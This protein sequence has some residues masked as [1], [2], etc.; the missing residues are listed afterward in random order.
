MRL[1][2]PGQEN[3]PTPGHQLRI[4]ASAPGESR[5][6]RRRRRG[7]APRSQPNRPER[8]RS[9]RTR[10]QAPRRT[11]DPRPPLGTSRTDRRRSNRNRRRGSQGCPSGPQR[12][13]N[14]VRHPRHQ[15]PDLRRAVRTRNS[16]QTA[17]SSTRRPTRRRR[18]TAPPRRTPKRARRDPLSPLP[19]AD[20]S[21]RT[22]RRNWPD[23]SESSRT[24]NP[25]SPNSP[26]PRTFDPSIR[27]LGTCAKTLVEFHDTE[28]SFWDSIGPR[29]RRDARVTWRQVL[30]ALS[31]SLAAT[32][33]ATGTTLVAFARPKS[34]MFV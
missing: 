25:E 4:S 19:V 5:T 15:R 17:S 6:E 7:R 1:A 14:L 30:R 31:R 22:R 8:S 11:I 29:L 13:L 34:G 26:T 21:R 9:R 24:P 3:S 12:Q 16:G 18:L 33:S 10:T 28:W 2:Q 32:D 23:S 27:F 20:R